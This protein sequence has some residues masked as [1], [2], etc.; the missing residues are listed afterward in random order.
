MSAWDNVTAGAVSNDDR[1]IRNSIPHSPP[2]GIA[3]PPLIRLEGITK[4]FYNGRDGDACASPEVHLGDS[5]RRNTRRLG[6]C[7]PDVARRRC[8]RSWACSIRRQAESIRSQVSRSNRF[9]PPIVREFATARSV[10]SF[11][12]SI[13]LATRRFMRR[14]SCQLTYRV[15]AVRRAAGARAEG[16]SSASAWRTGRKH[17]PAQLSGGQQQRVAVARAVAGDPLILLADEPTGNLDSQ[18][19]E[20][21]RWVCSTKLHDGGATICYGDARP[22]V[23]A[24]RRSAGCIS[25]TDA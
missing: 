1:D 3:A 19:G 20:Y 4:V 9:L 22:P 11:R 24:A 8:S 5:R 15:H 12:R 17:Y 25:S 2:P 21:G 6:V 7:H 23:R 14:G 10:W 13:S 16:A 18:N